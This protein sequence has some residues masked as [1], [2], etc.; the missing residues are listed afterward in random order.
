MANTAVA[1]FAAEP[2]L[3]EIAKPLSEAVISAYRNAG[4]V[5]N[6]VKNALHGV[7][8]HHPLHP[9]LTDIP[10]GAWATTLALDAKAATSR[11]ASYARAADFALAFGLAGAVGA[12]VTGL[13][14][15]S[16][17]DG[18]AKRVGLLHGL[19]NVTATAVMATAYVLRKRQERQA[20]EVCTLAGIGVAMGAAYL[21]GDLVY[22]ERIGVTHAVTNEPQAWTPVLAS[23]TLAEGTMQRVNSNDTDLLLVRQHGRVCALAHACAHLGGPLSEG[24]LKDGSVV[25]PWHGSEFR[26]EDGSVIN[27][28]TTHPQPNFAVRE[29][30]GQIEVAPTGNSR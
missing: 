4:S 22:A 27:G 12:A 29:R 10:I 28:P 11:D 26:L 23:S 1:R 7:W 25:C 6:A 20:G 30:D 15:W 19:L 8:L 14:D 2:A 17:T 9:V 21:G 24:E 3:D 16:E 13:T 5:G 18:R